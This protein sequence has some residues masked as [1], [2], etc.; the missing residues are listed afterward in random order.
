MEK[1]TKELIQSA[2]IILILTTIIVLTH[3][4]ANHDQQSVW[5]TLLAARDK[6]ALF[7]IMI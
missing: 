2:P 1:V 6:A 3:H 5:Q 4:L 7:K